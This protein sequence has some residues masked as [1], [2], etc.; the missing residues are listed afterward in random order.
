MI[1]CRRGVL[2]RARDHVWVGVGGQAAMPVYEYHCDA[3]GQTIDVVH[4]MDAELTTWLEVCYV[5]QVPLGETDP[6]APVR[7]VLTRAPG[8]SVVQGNAELRDQGFTK[9]VRRDTGV[10]ENVTAK[11]DE[12]RIVRADDD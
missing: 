9:L 5:A 8:V 2:E 11:G 4:S 1:K 3:N 10:Y 7:R 6:L 12:K